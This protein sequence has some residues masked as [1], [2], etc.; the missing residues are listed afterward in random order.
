MSDSYLN[1]IWNSEETRA[2]LEISSS[3]VANFG[4]SYD[5]YSFS[6]NRLDLN[7]FYK[8]LQGW[9]QYEYSNIN[10]HS[11][12]HAHIIV[13]VDSVSET[14][15]TLTASAIYLK[16]NATVIPI[17]VSVQIGS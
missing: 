12:I 15:S 2:R 14:C 3:V 7:V 10:S 11:D 5:F 6:E 8:N 1:C 4:D 13:L 16:S 9:I 17:N